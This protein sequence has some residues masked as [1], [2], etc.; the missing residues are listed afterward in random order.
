[1]EEEEEG[2][3]VKCIY[4]KN[5]V[6]HDLFTFPFL[7]RHIYLSF[8]YCNCCCMPVVIVILIVIGQSKVILLYIYIYGQSSTCNYQL[9]TTRVRYS[10]RLWKVFNGLLSFFV[11]LFLELFSLKERG[12]RRNYPG[13]VAISYNGQFHRK[14]V[15]HSQN[16]PILCSMRN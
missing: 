13:H 5:C 12:R 11:A 14:S 4:H 16:H 1:M 9:G 6:K 8:F 3:K 15:I 10:I 7:R 2:S